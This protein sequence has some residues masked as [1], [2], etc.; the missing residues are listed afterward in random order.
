LFKLQAE[1]KR[2]SNEIG[3]SVSQVV[4]IA[5]KAYDLDRAISIFQT[6]VASAGES[7]KQ[8]ANQAYG[9]GVTADRDTARQIARDKI[10]G[11]STPGKI[12]GGLNDLNQ[13]IGAA[14]GGL[15]IGKGTATSDSIPAMLSNGEY[16]VNADA[17]A[18]NKALLEAINSGIKLPKFAD[19]GIV[20]SQSF[21]PDN[22]QNSIAI[23]MPN[24][25]AW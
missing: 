11:Y 2:L 20:Q 12:G 17:T 24:F 25:K 10:R 9:G 13:T 15:I 7:L 19:G 6:A 22:A 21:I 23:P 1:K 8:L 3:G 18:K 14:T 4:L 16:V 5:G